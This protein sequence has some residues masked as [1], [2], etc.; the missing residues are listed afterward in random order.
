MKVAIISGTFDPVHNG[1]VEMAKL[2]A[3]K[4]ELDEVWFLPERLP[5]NKLG[6]TSYEHRLS[7]LNLVAEDGIKVMEANQDSHSIDTLRSLSD[8]HRFFVIVG[9]D[10][11]TSTWQSIDE[12]EQHAEIITFG[13]NGHQADIQFEHPASSKT[14][15]DQISNNK[16]PFNLDNKVLEYI[17]EHK[18]YES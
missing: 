13:R 4:L 9:A 18:L 14:I 5:R 1:H 7:M 10:V 3:S 17:H 11:D 16:N 2:A 6:V 15:R 8:E 12:I